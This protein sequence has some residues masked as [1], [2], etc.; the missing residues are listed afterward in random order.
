MAGCK[1]VETVIFGKSVQYIGSGVLNYVT[2]A[3]GLDEIH[4][5]V[6]SESAASALFCS[7]YHGVVYKDGL[8]YVSLHRVT[9]P[10]RWCDLSAHQ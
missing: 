6:V 5:E 1:N 8:P 9:V 10:V 7:G 3:E 2:P 4:I